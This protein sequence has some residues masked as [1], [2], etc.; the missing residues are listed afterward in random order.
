MCARCAWVTQSR[1]KREFNQDQ[2]A[3][4]GTH[5][6]VKIMQLC[7]NASGADI[8]TAGGRASRLRKLEYSV[9]RLFSLTIHCSC[10]L[11]RGSH[12]TALV[13]LSRVNENLAGDRSARFKSFPRTLT[14]SRVSID[15]FNGRWDNS[16]NAQSQF[17]SDEMPGNNDVSE[18]TDLYSQ[19]LQLMMG[20]H[21][22][23]F[24]F[25]NIWQ[26]WLPKETFKISRGN[27]ISWLRWIMRKGSSCFHRLFCADG[28]L[29]QLFIH[30]YASNCSLR[31]TDKISR[32]PS[33]IKVDSTGG[34]E[35]T[36]S[37][38]TWTRRGFEERSS[39]QPKF[40]LPSLFSKTREARRVGGTRVW[41]PGWQ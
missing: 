29:Y 39:T 41:R 12:K 27:A 37:E 38:I 11:H 23:C 15:L 40:S 16:M 2:N 22:R 31:G 10:E 3:L 17:G 5:A 7:V 13:N 1:S 8:R 34:T 20:L 9:C 32:R 14:F 25:P 19:L 4:S 30:D 21:Y 33:R 36:R 26:L 35:S 18:P 24:L 28:L 6:P